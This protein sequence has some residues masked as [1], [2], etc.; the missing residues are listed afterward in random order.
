MIPAVTYHEDADITDLEAFRVADEQGEREVGAK[1]TMLA[2]LI[3]AC[4]KACRS[5]PSSTARSTATTW[6]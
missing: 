5:S 6:C 2:F 4:V 1:L 3:K